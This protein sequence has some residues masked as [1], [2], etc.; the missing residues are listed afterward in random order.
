MKTNKKTVCFTL[1]K[2]L[3][4]NTAFV[5]PRDRAVVKE[6]TENLNNYLLNDPFVCDQLQKIYRR[7]QKELNEAKKHDLMLH[8]LLKKEISMKTLEE[9]N[10]S[11]KELGQIK[12]LIAFDK[13]MFA[14][15]S[16]MHLHNDLLEDNPYHF[17][18]NFDRLP[19][20]IPAKIK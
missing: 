13:D 7:R 4:T 15:E 14:P 2:I 20:K 6:L 8:E 9:A 5:N 1:A 12:M 3:R 16:R 17:F 18:V 19:K 10:V 11:Q